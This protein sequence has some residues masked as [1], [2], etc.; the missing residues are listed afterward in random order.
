LINPRRL[1]VTSFAVT[2]PA[3]FGL[4]QRDRLFAHYEDLEAHYQ[5]RPS[6][7]V[8][9][10]GTWGAGRVELVQIPTP[11]ETNDNIV[12]F[13]V[14]SSPPPPAQPYQIEYR[15][16]WQ[17][18]PETHPPNSWVTQSRRGSGYVRAP[19]A[20]IAFMIDFEGPVLKKLPVDAKVE[21]VFSAD[22]NG[23]LTEAIA[24]RNEI[25]GGWRVALRFNRVDE[26]NPTE[27]RGYLRAG[28]EPI[29]ETWSYIL[30]PN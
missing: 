11:D 16:L 10:K 9:P 17:K 2:D 23:K 25:T 5:S 30:E 24:F 15:L 19:D 20:S 18:E 4:M 7:W 14:P 21:A 22:A 6:I 28:S 12:A 3:G 27:L 26:K 13:W 8:V 1:L 29:S